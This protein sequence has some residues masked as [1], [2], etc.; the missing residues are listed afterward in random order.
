MVAGYLADRKPVVR[1]YGTLAACGKALVRHLGELQPDH[2]TRERVR[3]YMS[4]RRAEGHMVGPPDARRK[5]PTQDG[6]IIREL[7]TLRAALKWAQREKWISEIP[8]IAVP[9][10]PPPRDRWLTRAEAD[11]LLESA[12]AL[13]IKT[14]LALALYTAARAGAILDLTWDRVDF[15]TNLIDYGFVDGGKKRVV[16]PIGDKLLPLLR[17]VRDA[18]TSRYVVEH[19]SAK[20]HSVKTGTRAAAIRAEL[21]GVTPHILRHTGATWMAMAGVPME[22]IARVLGHGDSRVTERVYAKFSPD[23][24]RNAVAALTGS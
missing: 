3:F 24:L 10:Q 4:R 11:R 7:L 19:G 14:F 20:V 2:L 5:K 15:G 12:R 18:A 1:A 13:H 9:R 6:T 8:Y 23:F 17:M 21:P 22:Q 16:V